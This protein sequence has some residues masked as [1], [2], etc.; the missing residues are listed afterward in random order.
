MR[1]NHR[2]VAAILAA[3]FIGI[4][5]SSCIGS[6]ALTNKLLS[7]NRQIDSKFVNELVFIAFWILPVYEVSALADVIVINSIEFWSGNNPV[8][9][10]AK[11]VTGTDGQKYLVESDANG[12]TITTE[13]TGDVVRLDYSS[14]ENAWDVTAAGTTTRLMTFIDDTHV[15]LP[16]TDGGQ[17]I[18][19]ISAEGLM[20][21]RAQTAAPLFALR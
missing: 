18:V 9:A 21:Y 11:T 8:T 3:T 2:T 7:W 12:Y 5:A 20:A 17:A 6:F 10:S 15:A 19:E 1:K 14:E 13:A 4:T 16:A